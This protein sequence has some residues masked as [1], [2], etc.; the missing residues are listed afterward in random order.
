LRALSRLVQSAPGFILEAGTDP[1]QIAA[2][3]KMFLST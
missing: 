2:A 1:A 3:I